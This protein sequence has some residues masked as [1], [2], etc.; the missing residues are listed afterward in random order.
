M[1]TYLSTGGFQ[2]NP[3]KLL[4]YLKN[5]I[6]NIE[7]S[8]GKYEKDLVNKILKHNNSS[9]IMLHNYFPHFKE[10][11]VFNLASQNRT[12]IKKS[13][14]LAKAGIGELIQN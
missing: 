14:N 4:K 10:S 3:Q 7:L 13:L 1:E 12:I 2:K 6:S 9:K 8:G 5:R 11:F